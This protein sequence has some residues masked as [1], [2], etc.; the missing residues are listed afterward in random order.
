MTASRER[1]L[2]W[3]V[4]NCMD[5]WDWYYLGEFLKSGFLPEYFV[6]DVKTEFKRLT[7]EPS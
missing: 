4:R 6:K 7:K 5:M 3:S 1:I 2:D